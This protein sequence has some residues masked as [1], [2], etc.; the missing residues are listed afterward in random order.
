MGTVYLARDQALKRHV[1]VKVLSPTLAHDPKARIRFA[2]EAEAAAAVS[3]PNVVSVYQ[4][5]ELPRSETSYF[6]MQ[7]I[8]GPTL[9]EEFPEG[10]AVP[11]ARAKRIVGEVAS[12]LAAAHRRS[13]V[14]RD[15]KPSNIMLDRQS[16][17]AVVLDFGIS[18]AISSETLPSGERLTA[19][20]TTLGTPLYVSP[21]QAAGSQVTDRSD[22]YSLGVVAFELVTGRPPFTASTPMG[23]IAAHINQ[24]PPKVYSQRPDLDPQFAS[25]I[26]RCLTKNAERRP[27]AEEIARALL[28]ATQTL[29]EWPPPGLERLRGLG[30]RLLLSLGLLIGL[31]LLFFA[32]LL[33]QPTITSPQW[34]LGETSDFWLRVAQP[35][36][37]IPG[38]LDEFDL[39]PKEFNATPIWF[40]LLGTFLAA[41]TALVVLVAVRS[42]QLARRVRWALRSGYP[43]VVVLDVASDHQT[44]TQELINGTGRFAFLDKAEIERL[45]R[46][47]RLQAALSLVTIIVGGLAPVLWTIGWLGGWGT[48][49]TRLLAGSEAFLLSVPLFLLVIAVVL[50]GR[51]ERRVRRPDVK[52]RWIVFREAPPLVKRELVAAWLKLPGRTMQTRKPVVSHLAVSAIP[53][54]LA[55]VLL[56]AMVLALLTVS[57]SLGRVDDA[58]RAAFA[59]L[60]STQVDSLRPMSWQVMDSLLG[61]SGRLPGSRNAPDSQAARMLVMA[62]LRGSIHPVWNVDT[63]QRANWSGDSAR[64]DLD[65]AARA[66]ASLP[67][68]LSDSA[69]HALAKDTLTKRLGLLRR[70]AHASGVPPLWFYREGFPGVSSPFSLRMIP[71]LS[72]LDVASRNVF[73]SILAMDLGDKA[74]A[75]VRVRENVAFG[76][77]LISS[78]EPVTAWRGVVVVA[79]GSRALEEIGRITADT[80]LMEEANRLD[81]ALERLRQE[82]RR[83][84]ALSTIPQLL[85]ADPANPVGLR[86]VA[87][88]TLAPFVRWRLIS[89]ITLGFCSN[90]REVLFGPD[91]RRREALAT[92]SVKAADIP[93][94]DEWVEL[95]RRELDQWIESP[96]EALAVYWM[97]PSFAATLFAAVGLGG[98]SSRLVFCSVT[99]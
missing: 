88:S 89:A 23:L 78:G 27:A 4:V 93:R 56:A 38:E 71:Y 87:D 11:E 91:P 86:Y 28:P 72:T 70:V 83:S 75:L 41:S 59:W 31:G 19:K 50:I 30:A 8:D 65:V 24:D 36:A 97:M 13:L 67:G 74:T 64:V 58:R 79:T 33:V 7:M 76:S 66:W 73:T 1:A 15:I 26:D 53:S 48:E 49:S 92:A 90:G 40:F 44:D 47:R 20:G 21:E 16:G 17:R 34:H 81:E 32:A 29:I 96:S 98:V 45:L 80:V 57:T 51:P 62:G 18:A 9:S 60:D 25:L 77:R 6:L 69:R 55:I 82:L 52:R 84:M 10:K 54:G 22:V 85:M 2:R 99:R 39:Q 43:L 95:N 14:H 46:L 68:R 35:G 61:H 3:H 63:T 94:T 5:G 42:W 12:A 37:A